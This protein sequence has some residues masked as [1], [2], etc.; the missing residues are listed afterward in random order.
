MNIQKFR[1]ICIALN[2]NKNVTKIMKCVIEML[3]WRWG[4][5][6]VLECQD[7]SKYHQY[8]PSHIWR[9]HSWILKAK[10][11]QCQRKR[12]TFYISIFIKTVSLF[13]FCD[14]LSN[15]YFESIGSQDDIESIVVVY[16]VLFRFSDL[17]G[18]LLQCGSLWS[19]SMSRIKPPF[20]RH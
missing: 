20:I 15:R 5:L 10:L 7:Y 17:R 14:L 13:K 12:G 8:D 18:H 6:N 3:T 16:L 2:G 19:P 1:K 11:V 9:L 4:E